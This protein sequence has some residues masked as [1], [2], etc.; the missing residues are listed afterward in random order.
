MGHTRPT[1][2]ILSPNLNS[3]NSDLPDS[4]Q[5]SHNAAIF[6]LGEGPER[7]GADVP[8]TRQRS[9]PGRHP[10]A[11]V[12]LGAVRS[13]C[14]SGVIQG[15]TAPP[16]AQ[17]EVERWVLAASILGSSMAFIDGT[18]V[19]VALPVLQEALGATATQVQWVVE[20]YMLT[21]SAL[22]L[23]GGALADKLGRRR[24]FTLGAGLFVAASAACGLAPDIHWLIAARVVQGLGGALLIPTSLALLGACFPPERRGRAIGKWSAFSS[25]AA[26]VGP[27]LG[28]WLVQLGSWR[29]VFWI[30]LPIGAATLAITWLRVP[31]SRAQDARHLDWAGACLATLGLGGLVFGLLE[32]PRLGLESPFIVAALAGGSLI[33]GAF[34]WIEARTPEPMVPL[35]L[36]RSRTFSGAN[37]LTLLLYAALGATFFFL[38]FDLIQ[39]HGYTPAEAGAALLP[40]IVLLSLLSGWAGRLVDRYGARPPLILGPL[41]AALGFGL[42]GIAGTSGSYWT[43]FFPGV[44]VLGLGMAITVAPLTTTVMAAAGPERAGLASGINNAVSRTASLLAIAVYGIAAYVR[45]ASALARRLDALGVPPE[46]RRALAEE[47]RKLAAATVPPTLPAELR[48]TLRA[49]IAESFVD[50]F[51]LLALVSAGLAVVSALIAWSLIGKSGEEPGGPHRG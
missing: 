3:V 6:A 42:L 28:G 9:K 17:T 41:I 34:V 51:R 32:A 7:L 33:L 21:L 18:V 29:W 31:E 23:L 49:A 1:G 27:V 47:Q 35:D 10:H 50:A 36:F 43:T 38:P 12:P 44:V 5:F 22:L 40:L 45:F 25:A 20:G 4:R 2:V 8:G 46:V 13:P 48:T 39:V 19:N 14:D 30:N 15:A 16:R 11:E 37:L 26:G 24:I